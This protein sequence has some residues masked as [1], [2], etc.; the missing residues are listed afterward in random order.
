MFFEKLIQLQI[1]SAEVSK[2]ISTLV[3]EICLEIEGQNPS[4]N[5]IC[6]HPECIAVKFSTI[7]SNNGILSAEYYVPRSQ[8]EAVRK[9]LSANTDYKTVLARI[10]NMVSDK[11]V[12]IGKDTTFLNNETVGVIMRSPLWE[13]AKDFKAKN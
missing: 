11:K 10:W 12:S 4:A 3:E 7:A 2:D 5:T 13:A 1:L 8:A 6:N 9:A